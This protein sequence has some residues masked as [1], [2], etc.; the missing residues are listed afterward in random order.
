M[1]PTPT[2]DYRRLSVAQRLELVE[3][4]WDS[5]NADSDAEML[6]LTDEERAMLDAR[7]ADREANPGQGEPWSDVRSRILGRTR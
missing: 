7:V 2:F 5:I 1:T 4:I 6:P 3:D